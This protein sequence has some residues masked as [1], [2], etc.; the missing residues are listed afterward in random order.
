[1]GLE[2]MFYF[3]C[4]FGEWGGFEKNLVG[5]LEVLFI[6]VFVVSSTEMKESGGG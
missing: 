3:L 2:V 6:V 5:G 1:M 4:F